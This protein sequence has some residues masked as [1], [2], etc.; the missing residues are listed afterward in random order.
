[1]AND[2]QSEIIALAPPFKD[3]D[4]TVISA[5]VEMAK[6]FVCESRF[7]ASYNKAVALYALHLMTMDGVM[8]QEGESVSSYSQRV[9]SFSLTGE[10][11]KTY[12]YTNGASSGDLSSTPFGSMYALLNRMKGGGWGLMTAG[13]RGGCCR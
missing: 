3:V 7:G 8:R 11:S 2:I 4:P 10:F 13:G 1:M 12:S 5:W 9:S 6:I